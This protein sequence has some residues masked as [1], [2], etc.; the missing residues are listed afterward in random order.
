VLEIA[1]CGSLVAVPRRQ[2]V[3]GLC[4]CSWNSNSSGNTKPGSKRITTTAAAAHCH[5]DVTSAKVCPPPPCAAL[6]GRTGVAFE[7]S[8]AGLPET[9]LRLHMDALARARA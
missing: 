5:R 4:R 6:A 3:F 8:P 7:A 9:R 1:S 2:N